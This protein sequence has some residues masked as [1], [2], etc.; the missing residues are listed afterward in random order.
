MR[1]FWGRRCSI[2]WLIDW[3]RQSSIDRL[4]DWLIDWSID[5]TI[6]YLI[7]WLLDWLVVRL[8][9]WL[10]DRGIHSVWIDCFPLFPEREDERS[11]NS[12][13]SGDEN[14][15]EDDDNIIHRRGSRS[16]STSMRQDYF[17]SP[18]A[19][20]EEYSPVTALDDDY[21]FCFDL[22]DAEVE[23]KANFEEEMPA[24]VE[25]K[26]GPAA[27]VENVKDDGGGF[28]D[29]FVD[30]WEEWNE[31]KNA[32]GAEENLGVEDASETTQ[33][34]VV[35]VE[36]SGHARG[37]ADHWW[38]H[39]EWSR[40]CPLHQSNECHRGNTGGLQESAEEDA[41][42][43]HPF[44][45]VVVRRRSC[46]TTKSDGGRRWTGSTI[47]ISHGFGRNA[48][49]C[50]EFFS[51]NK[52]IIQGCF[53]LFW[54]RIR[55]CVQVVMYRSLINWSI[56]WLIFSFF[57]SFI[58]PLITWLIDWFFHWLIDWLIDWLFLTASLFN[59]ADAPVEDTLPLMAPAG[60]Q[61][62]STPKRD[63]TTRKL[64]A[65]VDVSP[66]VEVD[67]E[68][69]SS[70]SR[71]AESLVDEEEENERRNFTD[72]D[73]EEAGNQIP[74][75]YPDE[76]EFPDIVVTDVPDA[77]GL[78]HGTGPFQP[79]AVAV[80]VAVAASLVSAPIPA[81]NP[82]KQM[83]DPRIQS[84][85]R[86]STKISRDACTTPG[87]GKCFTRQFLIVLHLIGRSINA[88]S[89]DWLIDWLIDWSIDW[90]IVVPLIDCSIVQLIDWLIDRLIDWLLCHWLIVR[91]FNWLIDWCAIDWLIDWWIGREVRISFCWFHLWYRS[92]NSNTVVLSVIIQIL[93]LTSYSVESVENAPWLRSR[94]VRQP[95]SGKQRSNV[96]S[97]AV[98]SALP[99]PVCW[100]WLLSNR[101]WDRRHNSIRSEKSPSG[102]H[103]LHWFLSRYQKNKFINKLKMTLNLLS[104]A[105]FFFFLL[106]F[107]RDFFRLVV[108]SIEITKNT[109]THF[110]YGI[111]NE[112]NEQEAVELNRL[113]DWLIDQLWHGLFVRLIDWLINCCKVWLIDWLIDC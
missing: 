67:R 17:R 93:N 60:P 79:P 105:N 62:Y 95:V 49:T 69:R 37:G 25:E 70:P 21:N 75:S 16:K 8:I 3:L 42:T 89:I 106:V 55:H 5:R 76:S 33:A 30:E 94:R 71:I 6:D 87:D 10:I 1:P 61:A 84:Q 92:R 77:Y 22:R 96:L 26:N 39:A 46:P 66:F 90:L 7:L 34:E 54:L 15:E 52:R 98:D 58:V 104:G 9:A 24:L 103:L 11:H 28:S 78:M 13:S 23:K 72:D 88:W 74:C 63:R 12:G 107:R 102:E 91:L 14:E 44:G 101:P 20:S 2:D 32:D 73:E 35:L 50:V 18:S 47:W 109:R 41:G 43:R 80:S 38:V 4:I 65:G 31:E 108:W 59:F 113:I 27:A 29:Y 85:K 19:L 99:R 100:L 45:P 53:P 57:L 48:K 81:S 40:C 112:K 97:G 82:V 110:F 68:P 111:S 56:D 86:Q 64:S 51:L 83:E 36:A